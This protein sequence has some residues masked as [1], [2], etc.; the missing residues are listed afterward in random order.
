MLITAY[1]IIA[2]KSFIHNAS[3]HAQLN[4]IVC[5]SENAKFMRPTVDILWT[6]Q[7]HL[8]RTYHVYM[9][10]IY[11]QMGQHQSCS[12]A[13]VVLQKRTAKFGWQLQIINYSRNSRVLVE[14]PYCDLNIQ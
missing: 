1:M 10:Y 13:K 12:H 11:T 5:T 6:R 9:S 8:R 4:Q 2:R 3:H 14:L 7:I